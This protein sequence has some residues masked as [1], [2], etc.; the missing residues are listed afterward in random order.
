M[1]GYVTEVLPRAVQYGEGGTEEMLRPASTNFPPRDDDGETHTARRDHLQDRARAVRRSRER[2]PAAPAVAGRAALADD[3]A[4]LPA[5]R[6]RRWPGRRDGFRARASPAT[7]PSSTIR[8]IR[9]CTIAAAD[10]ARRAAAVVHRGDPGVRGDV[11]DGLGDELRLGAPDRAVR[12]G[13][14]GAPAAARA[15]AAGAER[16]LARLRAG[17][18]AQRLGG[19]RRGWPSSSSRP[20][21]P[22]PGPRRHD[23]RSPQTSPCSPRSR[24][25]STAWSSV[26]ASRAR[27]G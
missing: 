7:R 1:R 25:A 21:P 13:V 16:R 26:P 24:A 18:A 10:A 22:T 14:A 11:A 5:R 19:R 4:P 23:R 27:P 2:E 8:S 6:S 9:R 3:A 20:T 12:L 15:A 17:A